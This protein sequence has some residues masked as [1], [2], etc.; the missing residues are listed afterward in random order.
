[1]DFS[2]FYPSNAVFCQYLVT[3]LSVPHCGASNIYQH[4][5]LIKTRLIRQLLI[6]FL[7]VENARKKSGQERS[8]RQGEGRGRKFVCSDKPHTGAWLGSGPQCWRSLRAYWWCGCTDGLEAG[9]QLALLYGPCSVITADECVCVRESEGER[10]EGKGRWS[11]RGRRERGARAGDRTRS[12]TC[13]RS[14]A[15]SGTTYP[16]PDS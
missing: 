8:R 3:V 10:G 6:D 1:M 7:S 16:Q 5:A 2:S 9:S 14:S 15:P 4:Q 11:V 13:G 12:G